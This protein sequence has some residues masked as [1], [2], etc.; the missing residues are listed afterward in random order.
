MDRIFP[1]DG[2]R[3]TESF[4][5]YVSRDEQ[6]VSCFVT[7]LLA[8][9]RITESD[10]RDISFTSI[11]VSAVGDRVIVAMM[12]CVFNESGYV[13]RRCMLP[14]AGSISNASCPAMLWWI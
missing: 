1:V 10:N 5:K 14:P 13:G 3:Y 12:C 8:A 11:C 4:F 9:C 2:T 6:P 7:V